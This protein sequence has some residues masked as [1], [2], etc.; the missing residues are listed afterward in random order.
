MTQWKHG[1]LVDG[2]FPDASYT[3]RLINYKRDGLIQ[4]LILND[5]SGT[6]AQDFTT[7]NNDGVYSGVGLSQTGIGDGENAS[8]FDGATPDFVNLYSAGLEG[9]FLSS[10]GSVH[11]WVFLSTVTWA[12]ATQM[13]F[14]HMRAAAD[15]F[16]YLEK[17]NAAGHV[18]FTFDS[19][20]T[21]GGNIL[22]S[23]HTSG[24]QSGWMAIGAS[25]DVA[26]DEL[27]LYVDGAEIGTTGG[28]SSFS[29]RT[30]VSSATVLGNFGT[31]LANLALDG[32][33]AHYALWNTVLSSLDF[34]AI[35]VL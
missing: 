14:W 30:L 31:G 12:A 8:S 24:S 21:G 26:N 15:Q 11:L 25:W 32:K 9:D 35:G 19:S 10:Q 16:L 34:S 33:I 20:G 1:P 5:P 3:Q 22:S 6:T 23:N 29:T 18:N 4:Y 13:R 28:F 7:N 17:S 27:K 2:T